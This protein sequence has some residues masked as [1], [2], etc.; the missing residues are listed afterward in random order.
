LFTVT[1]AVDNT[2]PAAGC[3]RGKIMGA[4]IHLIDRVE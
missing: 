2:I 4:Y 3:R 1:D